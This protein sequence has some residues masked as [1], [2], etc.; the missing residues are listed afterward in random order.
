MATEACEFTHCGSLSAFARRHHRRSRSSALP[1]PAPGCAECPARPI[2]PY[3]ITVGT[4]GAGSG[5][6]VILRYSGSSIGAVG[7][8]V[9]SGS[10]SDAG[11]TLH[12]FTSTGNSNFDLSSLNLNGFSR[13]AG[14]VPLPNG[15]IGNGSL[16]GTS[17]VLS[18]GAVSAALSGNGSLPSRDLARSR[19][20]MR[21]I[22]RTSVP[23]PPQ[24]TC[25]W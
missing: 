21:S 8:T 12:T 1:V 20:P 13:T 16:S 24:P 17:F 15:T 19:S 11:S 2:R 23:F 9:T 25:S 10:G 6:I 7:G 4:G 14:L 22:P 5:R 3:T 18:N